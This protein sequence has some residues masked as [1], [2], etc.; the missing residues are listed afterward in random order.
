[1]KN[2][3]IY[4]KDDWVVMTPEERQAAREGNARYENSATAIVI[5]LALLCVIVFL[6]AVGYVRRNIGV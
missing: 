2:T 1:M 5:V 3:P 4:D 6:V